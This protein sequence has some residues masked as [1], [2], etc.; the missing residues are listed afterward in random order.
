MKKNDLLWIVLVV[1]VVILIGIFSFTGDKED[2][3]IKIGVVGTLTGFGAQW[4]TNIQQGIDLAVEELN[5]EGG[6]DGKEIEVIYEDIGEVD[7]KLAVS[8]ARKFTSVDKVDVIITQWA[9]DNEVVWPI[10]IENNI[11]VVNTASGSRDV[12][13]SDPLVFMIRPTDEVVVGKIVDYVLSLGIK[14]PAMLVEQTPYFESSGSLTNELWEK[15]TGNRIDSFSVPVEERDYR[16]HILKVKNGGYDV[17]FIYVLEDSAGL[18]LKTAKESG[19]DI[20][21][22]GYTG[23]GD[24]V[25][26]DVAKESAEGVVYP[27]FTPSEPFFVENYRNK[28]GKEPG[29]SADFGYDA[30]KVLAKAMEQGTDTE[31]ILVG[32]NSIENFSGASGKITINEFGEREGKD[33]VIKEIR[34]GVSVVVG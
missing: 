18:V 32:L 22:I 26:T 33:L 31:S 15:R 12:P 10:A 24:P 16:G 2:E 27:D 23:I 7:L 8:A 28:Y 11:V 1:L 14:N 34:N 6:V 19:L 4:G 17:V 13:R 21:K 30:I 29:V 9:E 20:L 3:K 25:V 5:A